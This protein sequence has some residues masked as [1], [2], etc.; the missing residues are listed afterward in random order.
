MSNFT[1]PL[2]ITEVNKRSWKIARDLIYYI[3]N[4]HSGAWVHLPVGYTADGSSVPRF[5]WIF[6]GHQLRGP[7]A[8]AGFIHDRLTRDHY[9]WALATVGSTTFVVPVPCSRARAD[10]I[11]REAL[12]VKGAGL[13]R[14]WAMWLA[15]RLFGW[16]A[17]REKHVP[18]AEPF[19]PRVYHPSDD[20]S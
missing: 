1:A 6:V 3:G 10:Q 18:L 12:Q 17:W 2:T 20:H 13:L 19:I 4:E 8:S 11:Y 16:K 15:V 5:A 14:R 7:N 9:Y